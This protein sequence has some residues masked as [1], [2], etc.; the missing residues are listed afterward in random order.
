MIRLQP[1]F[2]RGEGGALNVLVM[3]MN[4][5]CNI[6]FCFLCCLPI[7]I[8]LCIAKRAFFELKPNTFFFVPFNFS[9]TSTLFLM[10]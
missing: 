3:K 1:F 6:T 10:R 5:F 2:A 4:A 7:V 8:V 9:L